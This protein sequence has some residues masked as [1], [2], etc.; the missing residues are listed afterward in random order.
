MIKMAEMKPRIESTIR[1]FLRFS[2]ISFSSSGMNVDKD[3]YR[4]IP[5]RDAKIISLI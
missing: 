3:V 5:D 1:V 4:K 2:V